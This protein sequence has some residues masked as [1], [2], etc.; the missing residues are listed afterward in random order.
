MGFFCN[1]SQLASAKPEF[2]VGISNIQGLFRLE[3]F[4]SL[5]DLINSTEG[6]KPDLSQDYDNDTEG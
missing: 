3:H 5:N 4:L 2:S 6:R 1:L